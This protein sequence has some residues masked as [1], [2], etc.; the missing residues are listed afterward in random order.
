MLNHLRFEFQLLHL[1][2]VQ[3]FDRVRENDYSRWVFGLMNGRY[4]LIPRYTDM[5]CSC[6]GCRLATDLLVVKLPSL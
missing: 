2:R 1:L 3:L 4:I 5:S 6:G